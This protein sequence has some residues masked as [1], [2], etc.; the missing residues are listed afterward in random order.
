[1]WSLFVYSLW[2]L[3]IISTVFMGLWLP[4]NVWILDIRCGS[5]LQHIRT[6]HDCSHLLYAR[7]RLEIEIRKSIDDSRRSVG[8]H[9]SKN[10]WANLWYLLL[11]SYTNKSKI[12]SITII[13][14]RIRWWLFA[15]CEFNF[16]RNANRMMVSLCMYCDAT[17]VRFTEAHAY[18]S[19]CMNE[20]KR[21]WLNALA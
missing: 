15:F 17:Y 7:C 21:S 10:R 8:L 6:K 18:V 12:K 20:S 19:V 11:S 5:I 9:R 4:V 16:Y 3:K 13:F 2:D 14:I 1:M